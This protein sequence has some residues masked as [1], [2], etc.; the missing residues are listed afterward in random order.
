MNTA[1]GV[2]VQVVVDSAATHPS[3]QVGSGGFNVGFRLAAGGTKSVCSDDDACAILAAVYLEKS[4]AL[5]SSWRSSSRH[6]KALHDEQQQQEQ[7]Q[8]QKRQKMIQRTSD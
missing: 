1:V 2:L 3:F 5:L 6:N 4:R 8:Q 7:Q